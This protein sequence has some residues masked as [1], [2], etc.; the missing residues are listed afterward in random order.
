MKSK[1]NHNNAILLVSDITKGMK[2]IGSKALLN[3]SKNITVIDYQIQYLKKHYYPI[4]IY[5]CTGFEH[6]KIVK[7]TS[8]YKNIFYVYNK[9]Y[10]TSNQA[11]SLIQCFKTYNL[12]NAI[13]I[14]NG[15]VLLDKIPINARES[16]L[17]ITN[18]QCKTE[19]DIGTTDLLAS[20]Y[21][22]Y[23]LPNKWLEYAFLDKQSIN[24]I[25][26]ISE[27]KECNKLFLFEL[28]NLLM[29][30]GID[31]NPILINKNLPIKINN[32]K[33]LSIAKKYYEKYF[34]HKVK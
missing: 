10:E 18:K 4:N 3:L 7:K 13:I 21:L 26:S 2:S 20:K 14:A 1:S 32:I 27:S 22:F 31:I 34:H 23:D 28:I 8:K 11:D 17:V 29:D 12:D 33:D 15:I 9:N 19:F 25:L 30:N 5:I 24:T 16:S 6:D